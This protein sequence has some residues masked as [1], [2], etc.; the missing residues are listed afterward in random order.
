MKSLVVELS[1]V[2]DAFVDH[3]A[4]HQVGHDPLD[5]EADR[6][7]LHLVLGGVGHFHLLLLPVNSFD[8]SLLSLAAKHKGILAPGEG[9]AQLHVAGQEL[10]ATLQKVAVDAVVH[11]HLL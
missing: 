9:N 1:S 11:G 3:L 10:G 5:V 4:G 2:G 6:D 8:N 7:E